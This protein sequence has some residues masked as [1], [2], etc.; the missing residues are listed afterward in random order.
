MNPSAL[1]A[2]AA[3]LT[4]AL[5][6]PAPASSTAASSASES[7]GSLSAS[8]EQ[9]SK[10]SSR[11]TG[12]AEGPYRVIEVAESADRPDRVRLA[13]RPAAADEATDDDFVLLL[14]R[15]IAEAR[16]LVVGQVIDARRRPYGLEFAMGEPQQP[17]F[18]VLDDEWQ[19]GLRTAPVAL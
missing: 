10:G 18:L 7:V 15:S 11:A 19:R 16:R 1:R 9:S 8:V 3:L 6:L 4:S 12:V 17:F 14:P 13:L 2:A 5:S